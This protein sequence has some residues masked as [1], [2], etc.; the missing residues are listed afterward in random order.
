[1]SE[2]QLESPALESLNMSNSSSL[3]VGTNNGNT[4]NDLSFTI[5]WSP[6]PPI[7]WILP[8]IGHLG[9]ATSNGVACD[10]QG[11]YYVGD[12]GR[13]AFGKPTRALKVDVGDIPGGV[14]R[15]DTCIEEAN[16]VYR[17]RMH[18]LF[19][20]NC[21]SHVA[22]ALNRMPCQGGK[23]NMVNLCFLVF[24]KGRFL[25]TQAILSQF[26]PF[27]ILVFVIWLTSSL[28]K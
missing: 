5:L 9:I 28:T 8:F 22:C 15:W 23:W 20:D 25:S 27:L 13:M 26:G 3:S 18:N 11:P 6:L 17:Q 19:C 10:F 24:F 4:A 21:H 16:D 2:Q 7:T 12:S 14:E 1:M